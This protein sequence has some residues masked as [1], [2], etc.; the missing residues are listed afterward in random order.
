MKVVKIIGVIVILLIISFIIAI[1]SLPSTAYMERSVLVEASAEQV[2]LELISHRNFNQWSPWA[3]KDAETHYE[4]K[5]PALGVGAKITWSSSHQDIGKGSMEIIDTIE[6]QQVTCIMTFEGYEGTPTSSFVLK[7]QGAGTQLT[8]TYHETNISGLNKIFMLGIDGF[9][10]SDYEIG[11][12]NLKKRIESAPAFT[13]PFSIRHIQGFTY[14]G[15]KDSTVNDPTLISTKMAKNY[16]ELIAFVGVRGI[17]TT[18]NPVV[19]YS[20]Y[21]TN[22]LSF[23]CALPVLGPVDPE[24]TNIITGQ[25]YEGPAIKTSYTG[26]YE[27]M[28]KIYKEV[29]KFAE[30]YRYTITGNPWEEYANDPENE[31]DTSQLNT[32]IYYPLK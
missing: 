17:E 16:G 2:Y 30:Y 10:G 4:Y 8:W 32:F 19:F 3:M 23:T 11:L 14:V 22:E 1:V 18:G 20:S 5:G 28:Q 7:P 9:L 26:G 31:I 29:R 6:N 21:N 13:Y 12:D 15:I 24:E 25:S 27:D